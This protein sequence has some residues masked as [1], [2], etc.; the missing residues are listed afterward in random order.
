M[1]EVQ[2]TKNEKQNPPVAKSIFLLN[3]Y[4]ASGSGNGSISFATECPT[5]A[6]I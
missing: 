6:R 3:P 1:Y 2:K 4:L 5:M